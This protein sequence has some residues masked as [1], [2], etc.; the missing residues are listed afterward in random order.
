MDKNRLLGILGIESG[1]DLRFFEDF[2]EIVETEEEIEAAVLAEILAEADMEVFEELCEGYFDEL[3]GFLDDSGGEIRDITNDIKKAICGRSVILREAYDRHELSEAAEALANEL[4][5]FRD[6]YSA[7]GSVVCTS[8]DTGDTELI[9]VRDAVLSSRL[10]K[11]G[12]ESFDFD[13]GSAL[14]YD[15][16]DYEEPKNNMS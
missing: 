15:F 9:S 5:K 1:D 2:A 12:G 7:D 16:D 3:K 8:H 6:W 13:F 10:E 4:I 11:L 14:L